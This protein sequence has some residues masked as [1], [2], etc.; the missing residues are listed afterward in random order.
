[1]KMHIEYG[2]DFIDRETDTL[3]LEHVTGTVAERDDI[4]EMWEQGIESSLF[5][6][7]DEIET[8]VSVSYWQRSVIDYGRNQKPRSIITGKFKSNK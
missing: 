4:V 8:A 1:M 3:L 6:Q 5:A 7:F 2:I